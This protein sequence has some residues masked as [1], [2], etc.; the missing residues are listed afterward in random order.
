MAKKRKASS[1]MQEVQ[2]AAKTLFANIRFMSP[3]CP[4]RTI[5][6]TS[7]VPS[8]GKSTTSI[9]LAKAIA[10]SG[11][12]TLLVEADMRRRSL[13]N[14]LGVR[15]R[16]GVYSVLTAHGGVF[17]ACEQHGEAADVVAVLLHAL[18]VDGLAAC[19]P[20]RRWPTAPESTAPLGRGGSPRHRWPCS[21]L[22]RIAFSQRIPARFAFFR[23]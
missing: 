23:S 16:A 5:V 2:N 17:A 8:E 18:L 6:M 14:A 10:T 9:E 15:A 19:P 11:K 12:K 20:T 3:D 22:S 7:S 4:L 13:A 1:N 21:P